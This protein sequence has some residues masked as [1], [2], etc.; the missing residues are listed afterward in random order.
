MSTEI[1]GSIA[2][3]TGAAGGIGRAIAA[4]LAA[5]GV[6]LALVDLDG[7][8]AERVLA[9]LG[10]KGVAIAADISA[11][12]DVA[13]AVTE[14]EAR[15]GP[16]DILVNNAGISGVG[17]PKPSVDTPLEEW[18]RVM[19]VNVTAPFLF[20]QAVLPGMV[21]RGRGTILN[22]SSMAGLLCLPG[23]VSYA[24][25]KAALISLTKTLAMEHARSGVRVNAIC[26]SWADTAFIAARMS[27]PELRAQVESTIPVGRVATP[28]EIA[29]VALFLLSPAS[30]YMTGSAVVVDGGMSLL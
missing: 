25:S 15:L 22:V 2:L 19:A 30:R 3:V 6:A 9:E 8:G 1:D 28:D 16:L 24:A 26:P 29:D 13:A 10:A 14:A 23:R 12:E 20:C 21:E 11:P 17:P 5:A 4:R 27:Q 18:E 7:D